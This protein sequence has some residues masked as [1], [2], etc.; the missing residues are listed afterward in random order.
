MDQIQKSNS[1][2]WGK[3][4][5]IIVAVS[6]LAL[7]VAVVIRFQNLFPPL[8]MALIIAYLF[9]PAA[10]FLERRAHMPWGLSVT[11]IFILLALIIIGLLTLGGFEIVSQI[12]SLIGVI[13]SLLEQLPV[14]LDSLKLQVITIGPY[15]YDLS[16]LGI[17]LSGLSDQLINSTQAVLRQTGTILGSVASSAI[18]TFGWLLFILFV[19]YFLL[20]ESGGLREKIIS[21]DLRDYNEDARK[22]GVRLG[23]IW[24]AFLRGQLIMFFLAVFIYSVVLGILGVRYAFGLA[25][26]AGLARFLPYI[27]P[28]INWILLGL[29]AYFQDY[30]L[31]G[32]S[33]LAYTALV[34]VIAIVIDYILDYAV[35]TRIMSHTL[36]VHAAAIMIA[37]IV[38]ADL[39]GLLGVLIA[40]PILA[41]VQLAYTYV[42]RKLNDED[43]WPPEEHHESYSLRKQFKDWMGKIRPPRKKPVS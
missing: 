14:F 37:V 26:V 15:T 31:F 25:L 20:I 13:Q 10:S 43:P 41:T 18:S 16:K 35:S 12:Q 22:F 8:I 3:T 17:D 11:L 5:K 24:N 36:K 39:L 9:Y 33:P 38:A 30:K 1:P 27:G 23:Q 19:S 4:T 2:K 40:A 32:M 29:I 7:T 21:Y 42:F 34:I 6:L 28:A